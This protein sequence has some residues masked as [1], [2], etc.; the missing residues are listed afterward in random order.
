MTLPKTGA[1]RLLFVSDGSKN[2][3]P[4]LCTDLEMDASQILSYYARRWSI[5]V[6]FKDAKQ[7][8]YMAKEQ[9]NTFDALVACHSLV[10][11]RYLILVYI[12][13]KRRLA[14]PALATPVE[15]TF[16]HELGHA[17]HEKVIGKLKSGQDPFQEI[18]AELTAQALCKLVGKDAKDTLGNSCKYI[19]R[20]AEKA[21]LSPYSAC[22]KVIRE[23]EQ[24]IGLILSRDDNSRQGTI[25]RG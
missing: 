21:D 5:E 7:M 3:Q 8:L 15:K 6:F 24:E 17:A 11:I 2:W 9:S 16:F 19:E 4:L 23:T 10:M 22:M 12:L 1:V 20:Y 25:E 18:V 13:S 14:G